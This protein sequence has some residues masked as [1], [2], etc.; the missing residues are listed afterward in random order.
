MSA[1]K[2]QPKLIDVVIAV[3][4]ASLDF[5]DKWRAVLAPYHIIV[6]QVSGGAKLTA[7]SG[8]DVE[9]HIL[10]DAQKLAGSDLWAISSTDG[11]SRSYGVLASKKRFVYLLGGWGKDHAKREPM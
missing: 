4:G 6:V 1:P 3:T 8:F 5:L 2:P 10:A 11:V 9:V 7:P